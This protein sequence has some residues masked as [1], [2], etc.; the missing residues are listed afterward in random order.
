MTNVI[1]PQT[2]ISQNAVYP[3]VY[4]R[5]EKSGRD[6]ASVRQAVPGKHGGKHGDGGVARWWL[7]SVLA[8]GEFRGPSCR[9]ARGRDGARLG[10]RR[11]RRR[12]GGYVKGPKGES[13]CMARGTA[14]GTLTLSNGYMTQCSMIP[15]MAPAVMCTATEL[16]G[17]L[18]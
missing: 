10:T 5:Q 18:S 9:D 15:A 1:V 4:L 16:V 2:I 17:R 7:F 14:D 6:K 3:R 13:V 8:D 11:R 12:Q